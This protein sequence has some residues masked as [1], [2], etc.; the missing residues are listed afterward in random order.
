MYNQPV[1]IAPSTTLG[2]ISNIP[3]LV[4]DNDAVILDSQVHES[5]QT[6]VQLL[7]TRNIT[8]EL[9]RHNRMDNL[10]DRIK[11]LSETHRKVWYMADGVYSMYGDFPPVKELVELM[12][13]YEQFYLYVDD[14]HGM[15]WAG[16]NGTG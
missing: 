12:S 10:E 2:H 13:R 5:V 1:V 14:S 4:G 7:K 11:V 9:V 16:K 3:V 15:S 8:V 6:V